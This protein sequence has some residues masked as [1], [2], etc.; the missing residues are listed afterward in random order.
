[1]AYRRGG[2][3]R[4][5]QTRTNRSGYQEF[6]DPRTRRWESTHRRVAEKKV[7]GKIYPGREVHHIDGDKSNNRPSNLTIL[8]SA[9]HRRIHGK[10]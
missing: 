10:K 3:K 2:R 7:R 4:S 6:K 5:L 1:M 9:Q 8:S